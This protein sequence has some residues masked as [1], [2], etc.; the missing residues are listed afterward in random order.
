M[1]SH[2]VDQICDEFETSL[3]RG[4]RPSIEKHLSAVGSDL[5]PRLLYELLALQLESLARRGEICYLDEWLERFPED[6]QTVIDVFR[7]FLWEGSDFA[8]SGCCSDDLMLKQFRLKAL[9]GRGA[10]GTVWLAADTHLE[11]D[12]AI[13]TPHGY[14]GHEPEG[15]NPARK[16]AAS[17]ARL[18]HA[19]ILAVHEVAE[20]D[21][22]WFIVTDFVTGG[23]LKEHLKAN[24][25]SCVEAAS[26]AA[27]IADGLG[28]AHS[29]GVVHRDLKPSNILLDD[30]GNLLLADF[31]LA[32]T[33]KSPAP[34]D[35]F[36]CGSR[37]YMSP[38]QEQGVYGGERSDIFSLG[39]IIEDL[40][41]ASTS[42]QSELKSRPGANLKS[43]S[44]NR[45][46]TRWLARVRDKCTH[47]EPESR[48][49]S[50]TEVFGDLSRIVAGHPPRVA[51]APVF[52]RVTRKTLRLLVPAALSMLVVAAAVAGRKLTSATTP[53]HP[54]AR[55]V[56]LETEPPGCELTVVPLDPVTNDPIPERLERLPGVSPIDAHLLPGDY[57]IVAVL[58][59]DRWH[60]V[61]R[62]VPFRH[63]ERGWAWSNRH[64]H[65]ND[66]AIEFKKIRIQS[67]PADSPTFVPVPQT[68]GLL[69]SRPG[70]SAHAPQ[71]IDVPPF[72][73]ATRTLN[74]QA[75]LDR[76]G[77]EEGTPHAGKL[78]LNY[79]Q[80]VEKAER[81]GCR[82]PS[83]AEYSAMLAQL[84][85][86]SQAGVQD[87]DDDILEWTS[88]RPGA[89]GEGTRS[90]LLDQ[91]RPLALVMGAGATTDEN[92][93]GIPVLRPACEDRTRIHQHLDLAF[94]YVRSARP[95]TTSDDFVTSRQDLSC[96]P[97]S[98]SA[99]E[100]RPDPI[101]ASPSGSSPRNAGPD[102]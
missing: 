72:Q 44:G 102:R 87:L 21:G 25:V 63:E 6:R 99:G 24:P 8:R 30:R 11:R 3:R 34:Q 81:A 92:C 100:R 47:S 68:R 80:V 45:W 54:D 35:G 65:Y 39:R 40:L 12:V 7:S 85:A 13:K 18:R 96:L 101:H 66:D 42:S 36:I 27:Q 9:V 32:V 58:D 62:H 51:R 17:S 90:L 78:Y 59:D 75:I 98:F 53:P 37:A 79:D 4:A 48:Y 60:E 82:L 26:M 28:F 15:V 55:L 70:W 64:W 61:N 97:G 19:H 38:E 31:G 77:V 57:L 20:V 83:A 88:S 89:H 41:E 46:T 67:P 5:R 73:V 84:E 2:L 33:P 16:E 43:A 1:I 56:R 14:S 10:F 86:L 49:Q 50:A 94:R 71:Q 93:E 23:T 76:A 52:E 22:H 29:Q 95:R 74:R 69:V 91:P